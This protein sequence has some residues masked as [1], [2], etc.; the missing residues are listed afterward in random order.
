MKALLAN[1]ALAFQ[2][3]GIALNEA[4]IYIRAHKDCPTGKVQEV[5]KECQMQKFE[6]FVLRA[7]EKAA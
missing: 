5:I 1:E 2:N 4:V 3:K 7:K 6:R